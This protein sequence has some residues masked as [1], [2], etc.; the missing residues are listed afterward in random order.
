M[1]SQ[2]YIVLDKCKILIYNIVKHKERISKQGLSLVRAILYMPTL[3]A[4]VYNEEM[5][6]IYDRLVERGKP[7]ML[8]QM[9]VMR[10]VILLAHSLYKNNQEYDGKRYLKFAEVKEVNMVE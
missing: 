7:K 8:A 6:L 1:C 9:A 5:K 10:K 3:N 4:I 2:K